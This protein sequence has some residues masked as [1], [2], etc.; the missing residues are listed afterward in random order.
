MALVMA[1]KVN[2]MSAV[3]QTP[4]LLDRFVGAMLGTGVG[5]AL[6]AP[7]EEWSSQTIRATL[8]QIRDYQTTFLGRGIVTDD[9]HAINALKISKIVPRDPPISYLTSSAVRRRRLPIM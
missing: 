6:G 4:K 7:V 9:P 8:G 5:D 3:R 2:L 1:C